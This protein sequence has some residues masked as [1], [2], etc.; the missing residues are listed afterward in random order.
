MSDKAYKTAL[1]ILSVFSAIVLV[2]GTFFCIFTANSSPF[3]ESHGV[4]K[5][6]SQSTPLSPIADTTKAESFDSLIDT[7]AQL[8]HRY[9][10][11]LS[12]Y[13]AG[14]SQNGRELLMLTMGRGDKKALVVGGIH[15]REHITTKYLLKVIED[16][17]TAYE[18][19]SGYYGNYNIY[20][21]LS[22]YTLYIIPCVN[23]DGLEIISSRQDVKA[24]VRVSLLSEYKANANGVDLNRNFPIAWDSIN[25]NVN[26]PSDYYFKGYQSAS[27]PETKALIDLCN[28]NN[29]AFMLSIHIKGNCIFWGDTYKTYNNALYKA[30]ATDIATASGLYM[31]EPTEHAKD[32]GGGFENWFRHTF[33]R[34]GVCIELSENENKILPC[35]N[36]NYKDFNGFTNYALSSNAL[37]AA[38]SSQNT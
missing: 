16:Y 38:M 11:L 27:E 7:V 8:K 21:L 6:L 33:D 29:F 2:T 25:N 15:A 14:Y 5:S 4:N 10:D 22:K 35:G 12:L 24:G 32:Y 13:T 17:C 34:P 37:A 23:P 18:S 31:T 9:P 3:N 1:V 28:S 36:E 19:S 20:E 26:A 30:F